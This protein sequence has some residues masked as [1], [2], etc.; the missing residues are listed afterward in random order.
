MYN[1]TW[2]YKFGLVPILINFEWIG[3]PNK[4]N[5]YNN[6]FFNHLLKQQTTVYNLCL[7]YH[8]Y[9][10]FG[11]E[12]QNHYVKDAEKV[13]TFVTYIHPGCQLY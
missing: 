10:R 2:W 13:T 8:L 4:C 7:E 1:Y 3:Y 11:S 9:F 5:F 6:L 12:K